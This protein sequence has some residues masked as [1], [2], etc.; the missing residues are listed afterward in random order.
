MS[1]DP[2]PDLGE[3]LEQLLRA[4]VEQYGPEVVEQTITDKYPSFAQATAE[5][6]TPEYAAIL[7][8]ADPEF[9]QFL[10]A[11][12]GVQDDEQLTTE[13]V[14]E[15]VFVRIR[16][17]E[18]RFDHLEDTVKEQDKRLDNL[19][20][21]VEEN[22]NHTDDRV[23][24]LVEYVDR[25]VESGSPAGSPGTRVVPK[26]VWVITAVVGIIAFLYGAFHQ[27]AASSTYV[28]G[29]DGKLIGGGEVTSAGGLWYGVAYGFV[30]AAL[31]LTVQLLLLF[32]RVRA[33]RPKTPRPATRTVQ[34]TPL[35]SQPTTPPASG[36]SGD[37]ATGPSVPPRPRSSASSSPAP[38]PD[39][40][41][42][43]AKAAGKAW[44]KLRTWN[45]N[46]RNRGGVHSASAPDPTPTQTRPDTTPVSV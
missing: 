17:M 37:P 40:L 8:G 3:Q 15:G 14:L 42:R 31:A 20:E 25:K 35:A 6:T 43:L 33:A 27:V 24:K 30:A 2:Q 41:E 12:N 1:D 19:E 34:P 4:A 7:A 39:P 44:R 46:R 45:Q 10:A 32:V 21:V 13:Q 36:G 9:A 5:G 16:G 28:V 22:A 11:V 29:T 18:D 38:K 23:R 26:R